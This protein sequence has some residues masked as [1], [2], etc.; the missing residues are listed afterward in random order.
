MLAIEKLVRFLKRE[1]TRITFDIESD[2]PYSGVKWIVYRKGDRNS[3]I[4]PIGATWVD[5]RTVKF[6][7]FTFKLIPMTEKVIG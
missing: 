5:C 4:L 6:N 2:G 3:I 7:G 1:N